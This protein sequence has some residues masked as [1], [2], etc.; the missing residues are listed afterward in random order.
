MASPLQLTRDENTGSF[1][2]SSS[3]TKIPSSLGFGP[4]FS[5][6]GSGDVSFTFSG[7]AVDFYQ[8]PAQIAMK[9]SFKYSIDKGVDQSGSCGGNFSKGLNPEGLQSSLLLLRLSD[10]GDGPH[11]LVLSEFM[12]DP[13]SIDYAVV[14]VGSSETFDNTAH[15]FVNYTD[16]GISTQGNWLDPSP[17]GGFSTFTKG[18]SLTFNFAGAKDVQAYGYFDPTLGNSSITVTLNGRSGKPFSFKY[19]R[20]SN[21][22]RSAW[23]TY[24]DIGIPSSDWSLNPQNVSI[25]LRDQI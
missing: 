24:F 13:G 6:S 12:G 11:T 4:S 2:F 10:L 21:L 16:P 8:S 25:S 20:T 14:T 15:V 17:N 7:I 3:W 1:N 9:C 18:D 19:D 23:F 5:A 22:T